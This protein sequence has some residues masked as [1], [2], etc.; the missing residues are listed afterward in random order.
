MEK[1]DV[2][3]VGSGVIGT[4]AAYRLARRGF[5][6]LLLDRS[7]IAAGTSGACDQAILLQSKKPGRHLELARASAQL[8]RNL[9]DELQ[10]EIEYGREGGMIVIETEEQLRVMT[11]F[12]AQQRQAGL[13]VTLLSAAEARRIQPWLSPHIVAATWSEEDAQV[14]PML[15]ARAFARGARQSGARLRFGVTVTGLLTGGHRITGVQTSAGPIVADWVVLAA[16]P[17]TAMLTESVGCS[18][19]IRP[20]RGQ[21]I[22]TE[23]VGPVIR[24]GLL[25]ARYMAAKL[26]PHKNWGAA[27]GSAGTDPGVGLSL[28]RTA[29]GNLLIGGSREFVGFDRSTTPAVIHA[30]LTHAMRILPALAQIRAIRTMAGLRPYTPDSLPIVGPV[31]EWP[32]LIVAAGH[33]GDGIALAPITGVMVADL[34]AGGPGAKLAAGLGPERFSSIQTQRCAQGVNPA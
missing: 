12:V 19:P 6:V 14:N 33:E 18:L 30:I 31:P 17:Q 1:A 27:P 32:G 28:G 2:I 29:S 23:P 5:D 16:G 7:G 10:M 15:L 21:L 20:R 11:A 9:E 24:G 22:V 8:Y 4:S 3:V 34:L 13:S 25:C 26:D